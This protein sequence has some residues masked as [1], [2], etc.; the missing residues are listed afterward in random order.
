VENS[1]LTKADLIAA[2]QP[3]MD[4]LDRMDA[5]FDRIDA[6]FDGVDK[7][8]YGMDARFDGIDARFDGI[9]VRF[10]G[11]DEG[12]QSMSADIS[13]INVKLSNVDM[14]LADFT[15]FFA[16]GGIRQLMHRHG[17]DLTM[18]V[19]ANLLQKAKVKQLGFE[20][21]AIAIAEKVVLIVEIKSTLLP[22]AIPAFRERVGRFLAAGTH[23]HLIEGKEVILAMASYVVPLDFEK[24]ATKRKILT[25]AWREHD[26]LRFTN[27]RKGTPL[28]GMS[29]S[30]VSA[31]SNEIK[32][33]EETRPAARSGRPKR[34]V[35]EQ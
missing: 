8:L 14:R 32:M 34:P 23:Q 18:P 28:T 12:M 24:A 30:E 27:L 25:I 35:I 1:P 29:P 9:D 19:K 31:F 4:R 16:L 26:E 17:H 15:E 6:R 5:R 22:S 7:R 13:R 10:D 2:L 3:I 33:E 21:D 11:I 20:I